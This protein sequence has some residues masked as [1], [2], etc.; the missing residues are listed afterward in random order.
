MSYSLVE[1]AYGVVAS[2]VIRAQNT[3]SHANMS[4]ILKKVRVQDEALL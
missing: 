4:H 3:L 1:T 2:D